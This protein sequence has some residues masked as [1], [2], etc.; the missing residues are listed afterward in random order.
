MRWLI[1]TFGE[2]EDL[3]LIAQV[4]PC[5]MNVIQNSELLRT[6]HTMGI[7]VG[8]FPMAYDRFDGIKAAGP[9]PTFFSQEPV[10]SARLL[11]ESPEFAFE[12]LQALVSKLLA[13][14]EI[15]R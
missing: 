7:M 4:L 2:E 14:S 6:D 1:G 12:C 13:R 10:E 3:Y 8:K 9:V 5:D 11:K 15:T